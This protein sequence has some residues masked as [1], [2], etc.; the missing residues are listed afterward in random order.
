MTRFVA[1]HSFTRRAGTSTIAANLAVL[2][3]RSGLAVALVECD[4]RHDSA[5]A[6]LGVGV[7]AAPFVDACRGGGAD[8]GPAQDV[9]SEIGVEDGRL[10]VVPGGRRDPVD[11][12]DG[13]VTAE[14]LTTLLGSLVAEARPDMVIL[15]AEA[16]LLQETLAIFA[17]VDDLLEIIEPDPVGHQG[18]AV[19]I[20][21]AARLGVP[22]R[23]V[24]L[25]RAPATPLEPS[26]RADLESAFGTALLAQIPHAP[27]LGGATAVPF[28]LRRTSHPWCESMF[29]MAHTLVQAA[30]QTRGAVT[31]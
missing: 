25:N 27:E 24:L 23:W 28:V 3:A 10:L 30:V 6:L 26:E 31:Q 1:L 17:I 18:S 14:Q 20:D 19:T 21:V 29:G 11:G 22:Q 12:D 4:R 8:G 9:S 5:S 7:D 15:D 2:L 13:A 16:G